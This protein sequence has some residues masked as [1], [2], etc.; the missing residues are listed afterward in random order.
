MHDRREKKLAKTF[1]LDVKR[2]K[3]FHLEK[4]R[5][6][7]ARKVLIIKNFSCLLLRA[8]AL[9]SVSSTRCFGG[10]KFIKN[11]GSRCV[12]VFFRGLLGEQKD[13]IVCHCGNIFLHLSLSLLGEVEARKSFTSITFIPLFCHPKEKLFPP[14]DVCRAAASSSRMRLTYSP[15]FWKMIHDYC[16]WNILPV[17]LFAVL[18]VRGT[19]TS[20][21][22]WVGLLG[23]DELCECLNTRENSGGIQLWSQHSTRSPGKFQRFVKVKV[24]KISQ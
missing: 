14:H 7:L 9:P 24:H 16:N 22:T 6:L 5:K 12:L 11:H 4:S 15:R 2:P 3:I 1:Q 8:P 13:A 21:S 20:T 19:S 23:L 17:P 10:M 18:H